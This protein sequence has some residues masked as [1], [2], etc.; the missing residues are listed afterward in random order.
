MRSCLAGLKLISVILISLLLI[1]A[2]YMVLLFA[3]GKTAYIIPAIWH[4]FLCRIFELKFEITDHPSHRDQVFFVGNHLSHFD[5]FILGSILPASFVAKEDLARWPIVGFLC[6]LQQTAF[7]SRDARQAGV[8]RNN[9][10]SMIDEGK[11]IIL[12]PEGT[13]TRGDTVLDFKSSL[14]SLPLEYAGSG[15]KIQP[16]TI[17]L[18][19]VDGKEATTKELKDI[20]AW[21][22]DNPIS[23][24]AHM[25]NFIKLRGARLEVTFH[26]VLNIDPNE[27]RKN[28]S[29]RVWEIVASP[30]VQNPA[31]V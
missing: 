26:P 4:G 23:M 22:R 15:L 10:K 29:K 7:I 5:I 9:V 27:D 19:K 16:F 1:P 17:R 6:R 30:L 13:S 11:N 18:L 31:A 2:Q 28:L 25:I 8:V 14:F 24:G 3:K 20:Y 21:D 12:F